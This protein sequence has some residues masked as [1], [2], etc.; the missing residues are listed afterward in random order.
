M[1]QVIK[2]KVVSRFSEEI[3][4]SG[5]SLDV[6]YSRLE[7]LFCVF[8]VQIRPSCY[9][10]LFITVVY[11]GLGWGPAQTYQMVNVVFSLVPFFSLYLILS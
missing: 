6:S 8:T 7:S 1:L 2:L 4:E 11:K 9:K 3:K 10:V 5:Q